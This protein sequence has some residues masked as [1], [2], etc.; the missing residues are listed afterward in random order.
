MMLKFFVLTTFSLIGIQLY[1]GVLRGICVSIGN[2]TTSI[3]AIDYDKFLN[4]NGKYNQH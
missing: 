1:K 2:N 3:S 4:N